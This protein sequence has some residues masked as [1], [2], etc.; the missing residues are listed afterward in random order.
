MT[1]KQKNEA[2]N[3]NSTFEQICRLYYYKITYYIIYTYINII[4]VLSYFL[5][6]I[7]LVPRPIIT[8]CH[9]NLINHTC[10]GSNVSLFIENVVFA[11][12]THVNGDSKS[13][14]F[15]RYTNI[16]EANPS[17]ATMCINMTG[18]YLVVWG[19]SLVPLSSKGIRDG[20]CIR[21]SHRVQVTG[22]GI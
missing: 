2:G 12:G 7:L 1:A 4:R 9:R 21:C 22:G 18:E 13:P 3:Q 15:C 16:F 6:G 20:E 14:D 8:Q 17:D 5:D 10:F 19:V 11:V